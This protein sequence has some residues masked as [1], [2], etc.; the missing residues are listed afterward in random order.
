MSGDP[1]THGLW[2]ASA[3]AAPLACPLV[4]DVRADVVVI[5]AGF[6]GCSAALHIAEAG[7]SAVVLEAREIGFG[8]SGRNVGLVNAGMWVMPEDMPQALGVQFGERM[9]DRLGAA[10]GLVFDLIARHGIPCEAER[11]GTLHCAVGDAGLREI[12]ERARQWRARGADVALLDA[13]EAARWIGSRA[14][15][16]ALLDRRAGTIQP[17]AY[18]RGLARAATAAG[19]RIHE[20]SEVIGWDDLGSGWR[21]RTASGS[22]TAPWVIVATDAYSLGFCGAPKRGQVMLPYFNMATAPLDEAARRE[23]LPGRQGAWDTRQILSSFRLDRAGR[24]V[25]GSVGALRR[26]GNL[27]HAR[28]SR[29]ELARLFPQLAEVEFEHSWYGFIGM[30]DNS[31]PNFVKYDRNIYSISGFNGRGIA[32]GT[33]FGRDLARLALG[34]IEPEH[35][36]LPLTPAREARLRAAKGAF[37]EMGAQVAHL[38]GIRF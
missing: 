34:E 18:V 1:L 12:T 36:A 31:L 21:V 16:G 11:V 9:L 29:G 28:W 14:Y 3:P 33:S 8:A 37:Y 17:L 19:A 20:W 24:L 23:I 5:G 4:G 26:G 38:T 32:P 6:T 35:L 7:R 30:T 2:A 10:P 27:V 22:V 15:S 25:F 13:G